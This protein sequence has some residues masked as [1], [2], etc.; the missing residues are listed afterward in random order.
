[1]KYLKNRLLL[2]FFLI[3]SLSKASVVD[4]IKTRVLNDLIFNANQIQEKDVI[5]FINSML[6]NGSWNDIN[7]KS[8][9]VADD[10]E[11]S[12]H[13]DR[14]K[15]MCYV[16]MKNGQNL[17]LNKGLLTKIDSG[18]TYWFKVNPSSP[19]WWHND[20][21]KQ[22]RFNIIGLLMEKHL[23]KELLTKIV[24]TLS[25]VPKMTGANL[26]D[27]STSVIYRGL[28]EGDLNRIKSGL[29]AI[30]SE[31]KLSSGEGFKIDNSFH[32]H[33]AFLYNGGYGLVFLN[34]CSFWAE[35]TA[36]TTLAFTQPKIAILTD[37]LLKGNCWMIRGNVMD[38]STEGR[39]FTRTYSGQGKECM[40][41]L[42][43]MAN[44]NISKKNELT[45]AADR[46]QKGERQ[47]ISGNQILV[48]T[49]VHHFTHPLKCA[50][51]GL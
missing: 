46:I 19:N 11:P 34:T 15:N 40:L 33:G 13:L 47:D 8:S 22:M 39:G 1:M 49:T 24:N 17:Y 45:A 18:L 3:V 14:L 7:Y 16:Y 35:K 37:M 44:A 50:Q 26:T 48:L 12:F 36:T 29:N 9:A 4:T 21:G 38:Y 42:R 5:P 2:C 32:Q 10:W 27:I 43:R 31:I 51:N 41:Y 28:I 20:I 6:L 25:A 30:S 23:R